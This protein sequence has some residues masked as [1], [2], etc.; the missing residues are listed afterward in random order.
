MNILYI[1]NYAIFAV[2]LTLFS[3]ELGIALSMLSGRYEKYADRF[4]AYLNPIWQINGTF[5][6]FYLVNFEATYPKLLGILASAYLVPL[7]LAALF[8]ILRNAFIAYAE[9]SDAVE[10]KNFYRVY[11]AATLTSY[12]LVLSVLCSAASGLGISLSSS[13]ID[14]LYVLFNPFNIIL[15][16]ASLLLSLFISFLFFEISENK[17]AHYGIAAVSLLAL[18]AGI[19]AYLSYSVARLLSHYYLIV[20]SLVLLLLIVWLKQKENRVARYL[21]LI[22]LFS[23]INILGVVLYPYVFGGSASLL[24]Y[25]TNGETGFWISVISGFGGALLAAYMLFF[26][27]TVY[28][29]KAEGAEGY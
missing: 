11:G 4:K 10:G 16:A 9:H 18:F 28:M 3:L 27:Y 8:L 22:W 15:F 5:A 13:S 6:V 24:D 2:F 23:G 17:L 25:L 21:S 1:I 20:A 29:K 7:M 26:I 12:F 14:L 19:L